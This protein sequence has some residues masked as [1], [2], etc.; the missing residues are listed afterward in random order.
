MKNLNRIL[1]I[2][3][4]ATLLITVSCTK[5]RINDEEKKDDTKKTD[6]ITMG[7]TD[8]FYKNNTLEEQSF[9][10]DSVH[11]DTVFGK[12]GTKIFHISKTL[13][14]YR[15]NFQDITYP[16]TLKLI[17][18]YSIGNMILAQLPNVAQNNIL[19]SGGEIK[20][21]AYKDNRELTL[22]E[23]RFLNIIMPAKNKDPNMKVFYGFTKGTTKDWN[24]NV[25]NTS[26]YLFGNDSSNYVF[27]N[28]NYWF[29]IVKL[30]WLNCDR[31]YNYA[32]TAISITAEPSYVGVKNIDLYVIFTN[33]HAY[34][35]L[36]SFDPVDLPL[37]EP[38]TFLAIASDNSVSNPTYYYFKQDYTIT[39][40]LQIH[41]TLT[42]TTEAGIVELLKTL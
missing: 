7:S 41:I 13:F 9:V 27:P 25:T 33:I 15:D 2:L 8:A 38:I 30:G 32:K 40:G 3:F 10:I 37:G 16:F 17:E 18:A 34:I 42:S 20:V 26:D 24:D 22:K 19:K 36:N 4:L 1:S 23:G 29:G 35:K 21:T 5:D 31:F 12:D 6:T 14:M 11:G 39:S 28:I